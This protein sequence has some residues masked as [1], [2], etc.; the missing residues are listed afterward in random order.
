M[1]TTLFSF[2]NNI[3]SFYSLAPICL[4]GDENLSKIIK[5]REESNAL[6]NSIKLSYILVPYIP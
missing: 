2:N 1:I 4:F 5:M 3:I 6:I